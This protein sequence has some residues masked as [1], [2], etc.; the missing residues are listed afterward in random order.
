M[1]L[2]LPLM[3]MVVAMAEMVEGRDG[4]QGMRPHLESANVVVGRALEDLQQQRQQQQQ[5]QHTKLHGKHA[6]R[7]ID[8][9]ADLGQRAHVDTER[10][11]AVASERH[12]THG[13]NVTTSTAQQGGIEAG[14]RKRRRDARLQRAEESKAETC[15]GRTRRLGATAQPS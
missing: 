1:L 2:Q 9:A 7:A 14:Q 6:T 11:R 12:S 3:V 8:R 5:Q 4:M 13:Q 10:K 15:S